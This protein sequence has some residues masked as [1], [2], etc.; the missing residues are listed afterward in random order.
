MIY[1]NSFFS[2]TLGDYIPK[3]T[4]AANAL[5]SDVFSDCARGNDSLTPEP[6]NPG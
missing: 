2:S 5:A 4:T 6:C 3:I 1:G